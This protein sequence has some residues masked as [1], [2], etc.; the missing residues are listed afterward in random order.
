MFLSLSF[1]TYETDV[2]IVA[3]RRYHEDE[4]WSWAHGTRVSRKPGRGAGQGRAVLVVVD[5]DLPHELRALWLPADGLP[6]I[7]VS[8]ISS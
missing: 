1:L 4:M 2:M 8:W 6:Q 5:V 7:Q 3:M